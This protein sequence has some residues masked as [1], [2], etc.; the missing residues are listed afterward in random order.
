MD[1]WK[2]LALFALILGLAAGLRFYGLNWDQRAHLHP[3]ERF[4][5][6]V[7]TAMRWPTGFGQYLD[8]NASPLNPHNL[9]FGFYVYGTFPVILVRG[10]AELLGKA[11]YNGLTLV[12]RAV[13]AGF[14]LGTVILVALLA[15]QTTR[16]AVTT[17]LSA[18]VYTFMILPIQQAH[19]F[20]V[21]TALVFF[22]TLTFIFLFRSNHKFSTLL[23]AGI[24]YGLTF[25]SKIAAITVLPAILAAIVFSKG[26]PR[27]RYWKEI[28]LKLLI[29]AIAVFITICLAYPY[30]FA[31]DSLFA[32]NPKVLANLQTLKS[33]DG[34]TTTFPPAFQWI[35]TKPYSYLYLHTF[36]WGLGIPIGILSLFALT[37]VIRHVYHREGNRLKQ[38]G[39]HGSFRVN[40]VVI[41]LL[42][43]LFPSLYYGGQFAKALRYLYPTYPAMAILSGWFIADGLQKLQKRT[44]GIIRGI[45]IL[46][47]F[48]WALGF[49]A[50]YRSPHSRIAASAWIYENVPAESVLTFESWDDPLP[51]A[52]GTKNLQQYE[53]ITLEMYAPDTLMKW[54][55]LSAKLATAD[56]VILSSNRVW[57]S[58][59]ALPDRFP[60]TANYYKKLFSGELGFG[61]AATFTS[62]PCLIPHFKTPER[63]QAASHDSFRV[64]PNN[65]NLQPPAISFTQTPYCLLAL[66]DDGA[67]ESFTVYDHPKVTI[68]SNNER[69]TEEELYTLIIGNQ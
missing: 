66:N 22:L 62:Y 61:P 1:K 13:S 21:D 43:I 46:T 5:T 2:F 58:L 6:M 38:S 32:L 57:R 31:S 25:S 64:K 67:E 18:V 54:Q 12:G 63:W 20:T 24:A 45:F 10:L 48:L 56:Y 40:H 69:K 52:L 35:P 26:I 60:Y 30:L 29:F 51:V 44:V 55:R 7:A 42:W 16:N 33:F 17:L 39:S 50:I 59:S 27:P 23:L 3:D 53:V 4:L 15:Y 41:L 14:E 34:P 49:A 11:D 9:G 36:L 37:G 65:I 28:T 47:A 68:F 19:F 8:T